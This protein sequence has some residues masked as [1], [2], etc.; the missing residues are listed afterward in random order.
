MPNPQFREIYISLLAKQDIPFQGQPWWL[1]AVCGPDGWDV[2]LA[3]DDDGAPIGALPYG[4]M[5]RKGLPVVGMPTFTSYFPIWIPKHSIK[6]ERVYHTE[7]KVIDTLIGQ[8]PSPWIF[9]Q[10]YDPSFTDGLGFHFHGF[11]VRTRYTYVLDELTDLAGVFRSM[12]SSV[13][14]H[15]RKAQKV[16]EISEEG[17]LSELFEMLEHS[18]QRQQKKMPFSLD[19]LK[20]ADTCLAQR[21][22][23]K[24]YVAKDNFGV[25]A[26]AYLVFDG[27]RTS[28]LLSGTHP[29][30]RQSGA[31]YLLL[32]HA[33]KDAAKKGA[34]F[35]FEGSMLPNIERVFRSFGAKR[36]PYLRVV[37]YQNRFF[38][39]LATLLGKNR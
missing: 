2:A 5:G 8:L 28:F 36:V 25:H 16:V 11:Q 18:F 37:R 32:W 27:P 12:E 3:F 9:A 31:L 38:E 7:R 23:R 35:D 26:A 22:M 19:L 1:D 33:I 10:Q 15:I 39:A 20:K 30:Y 24:I 29:E 4:K 14:N 6:R 34:T 17:E 21:G 13:R